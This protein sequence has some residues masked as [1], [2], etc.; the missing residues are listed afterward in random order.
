M[1]RFDRDE[2]A[3]TDRTGNASKPPGVIDTLGNGYAALVSRPFVILPLLLLDVVL[4]FA[5]RVRMAPVTDRLT[6]W[7]SAD[8]NGA[9]ELTAL[10]DGAA[11]FNAIELATLRAP[12][13]RTP[14]FAPSV[15]DQVVAETSWFAVFSTLP[16]PAVLAISAVALALG[17]L[18]SVVYRQLLA[19]GVEPIPLRD[20]A[21]PFV[22]WRGMLRLAGW[23]GAIACVATLVAMPV[24]VISALGF[25]FGF[26]GMQLLW[27]ALLIP[28]M[29]GFLHFF[30]SIHA[31]FVDQAG[32]FEALRNSYRVV[33][34][35]FWQSIQFIA[36]TLLMTTGLTYAMQ[37][38]AAST[39]GVLLGVVL[40]AFVVSGI[41]VAAMMFYRDRAR[42][43]GLPSYTPGR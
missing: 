20:I 8:R 37:A 30:F 25:V 27:I 26:G 9:H 5:P 22:I 19:S 11:S 43:L 40:N 24:V 32:P 18:F 3:H 39:L 4:L 7:L 16:L 34:Q 38:V 23:V 35:H 36:T 31:L 41:I 17:L 21:N 13:L 28:L 33:Q 10:V 42:L 29:W 2:R 1:R 15:G 14:A 12:L 6:G